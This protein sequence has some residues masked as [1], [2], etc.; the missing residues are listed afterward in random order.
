MI[1]LSAKDDKLY[2]RGM[3]LKQTG[4]KWVEQLKASDPYVNEMPVHDAHNAEAPKR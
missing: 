1:K 3:I 4:E 2:K